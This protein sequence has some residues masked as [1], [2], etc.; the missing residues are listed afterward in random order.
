MTDFNKIANLQDP[1]EQDDA[2]DAGHGQHQPPDTQLA[3]VLYQGRF[4]RIF[5]EL[6]VGAVLDDTIHDV[7]E[8][9]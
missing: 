9:D 4:L 5:I 7:E 3:V 6:Y 2:V 1:E 8:T